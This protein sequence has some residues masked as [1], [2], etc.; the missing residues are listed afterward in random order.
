ML[1]AFFGLLALFFYAR[2]AQAQIRNSR[3]K[4]QSF[5]LSLLFCA[6]GLM[7]KPMLVTWPFVMLLLDYWPLQRM[8]GDQWRVASAARLVREKMPFFVL[9]AVAIIMTLVAQKN[10]ISSVENLPLGARVGNALISYCRYL[11]KMFWP[12]DLAVYYPSRLGRWSRCCWR[13]HSWAAF[14]CS[15]G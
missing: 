1:S 12:T 3:L 15:H 14:R 9:A 6:L 11:G 5:L 2:Y 8:T 10:A 7:S 13:V 4:T